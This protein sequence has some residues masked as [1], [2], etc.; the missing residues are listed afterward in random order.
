[1]GRQRESLIFDC[2][3][4]VLK[5]Y[6]VFIAHYTVSSANSTQTNTCLDPDLAETKLKHILKDY[7][8]WILRRKGIQH[9]LHEE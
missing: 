5:H 6:H 3:R 2:K 4:K 1:M 9:S 7:S 8:F